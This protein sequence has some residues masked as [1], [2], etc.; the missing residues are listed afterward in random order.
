[1]HWS[2]YPEGSKE[3]SDAIWKERERLLRKQSTPNLFVE[4]LLRFLFLKVFGRKP[5]KN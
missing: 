4:N 3:R 1:M 5:G 2:E